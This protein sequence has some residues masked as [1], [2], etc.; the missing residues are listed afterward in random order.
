MAL[1]FTHRFK[2]AYQRLPQTIQNKV[3]KAIRLLVENPGH[4]SLR[5]KR[6]QGT[7]RIFEGRVDLKYRFSF[8]YDND[9]ILLR[10]VD[11]HDECL[12]NP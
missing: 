5:I 2:K 11:N 4:P 7:D 10:N 8:E 6:I 1:I 9:D 12:K 3:K